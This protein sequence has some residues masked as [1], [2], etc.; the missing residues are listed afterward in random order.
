MWERVGL[1]WRLNRRRGSVRDEEEEVVTRMQAAVTCPELLTLMPSSRR[2]NWLVWVDWI[3]W[4]AVGR[5][6][7]CCCQH[8]TIS[9]RSSTGQGKS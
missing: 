8:H 4:A 1:V 2:R 9:S 5:S 7:G 3:I 6:S